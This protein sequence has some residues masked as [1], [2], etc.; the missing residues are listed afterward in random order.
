MD[1]TI[2]TV[3]VFVTQC[4]QLWQQT[5]QNVLGSC[6]RQFSCAV[7]PGQARQFR[8]A[9]HFPTEW[10]TRVAVTASSLSSLKT[11]RVMPR[12]MRM[13]WSV[14]VS[15]GALWI[16]HTCQFFLT[17]KLQ[18]GY[19]KV[20]SGSPPSLQGVGR[21]QRACSWENQLVMHTFVISTVVEALGTEAL[22]QIISFWWAINPNQSELCSKRFPREEGAEDQGARRPEEWENLFSGK[23]RLER[24]SNYKV[25]SGSTVL[26][27]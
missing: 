5:E 21:Q 20:F 13:T 7:Q 1:T 17:N 19:W 6:V 11:G 25:M 26:K 22:E 12:A 4:S 3:G 9:Y 16:S 18:A 24:A 2:E 27:K 15:Q 8:C 10:N 14:A 23:N